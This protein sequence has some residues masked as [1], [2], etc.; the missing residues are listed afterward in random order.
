M[1]NKK[2]VIIVVISLIVVLS[3][4]GGILTYV[5]LATDAFKSDREKFIEYFSQ[6]IQMVNNMKSSGTYKQ[7][8]DEDTFESNTEI[9]VSNSRG[10]EISSPLN[11]LSLTIN[12]Q[13]DNVN[14]YSYTNAKVLFKGEEYLEAELIKDQQISGVRFTDVVKQFVTTKDGDEIGEIPTRIEDIVS[15]EEIT[16]IKDKYL[17]IIKQELANATYNKNKKVMITYN[18]ATIETNAYTVTLS[19]DQ[20]GNI[21]L[22]TLEN[23][24][25]DEVILKGVERFGINNLPEEIDK[26]IDDLSDYENIYEMKITV[27]EQND[28]VVRTVVEYAGNIIIIE[29]TIEN[30]LPKI[31]LQRICPNFDREVQ[32]T[33]EITKSVTDNQ[34]TYNI[35]IELIDGEDVKTINLA[36]QLTNQLTING[37]SVIINTELKYTYGIETT[38]ITSTNTINLLDSIENKF[39][40]DETNNVTLTDLDET[41]R[42]NVINL[43]KDNVP[44]VI[45]NRINLLSELLGFKRPDEGNEITEPGEMTQVEVNRFNAKFEFYTGN[46]VTAENVKTLLDVVKSNIGNVEITPIGEVTEGMEEEDIKEN[47][48]LTIEKDKVNEELINQVLEKI[49]DKTK[50]NV[51]ISYKQENGLIDYITITEAE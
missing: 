44:Q 36:N 40:L 4:I 49:D 26:I 2:I 38:I 21:I 30:G 33:L 51:N 50:Y 20:I 32:Q 24:K 34:E 15:D 1:R 10:G 18:N 25:T 48:K 45:E 23:L 39:V 22:T 28:V 16:S 12:M 41:T 27:Y 13:R 42:K 43:L 47:I 17:N 37:Q 46:S 29:N 7:I 11:E 6:N 8:L 35:D 9:K 3:I 14:Q 31:K 19:Q 5:F